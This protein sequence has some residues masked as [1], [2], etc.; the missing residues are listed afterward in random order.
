LIFESSEKG[1]IANVIEV[2]KKS[3]KKKIQ[4]ILSMQNPPMTN[5]QNTNLFG[6]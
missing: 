2:V 1:T 4:K 6:D 5:S 3:T